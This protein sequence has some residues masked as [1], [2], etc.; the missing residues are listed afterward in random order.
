MFNN[1]GNLE[2][3]HEEV[4]RKILARDEAAAKKAGKASFWKTFNEN[5]EGVIADK[6]FRNTVLLHAVKSLQYASRQSPLTEATTS[7]QTALG[8]GGY[9]KAMLPTIITR[10]F[11]QIV[12]TKFI[13][14]R[15]LDVPTQLIQTFRL[16][17]NT[18]KN[19]SSVG[20]EF[21]DPSGYGYK[22]PAGQKQYKNGANFDAFYSSQKVTELRTPTTNTAVPVTAL[23]YGTF[24]NGVAGD[25]LVPNS[26]TVSAVLNVDP[27]VRLVVAIQS[28]ATLVAA[29]SITGTGSVSG[30]TPTWTPN[31]NDNSVIIAA[32][33]LQAPGQAATDYTG[34]KY[35]FSYSYNQERNANMSE[36]S[37]KMSTINAVA[38]SRKNFAQISAE[39]IQD[40]EAYSEGK[41]DALKELVSGMTESMA[42][43]ID[44]E[45]MLAMMNSAGKTSAYDA[46]YPSTT[47]H[48]TT[49]QKNQEL[50][51]RMNY[52]A[53][54]MSIDFLRGEGMF[55]I[56]HPHVFTLLQ[57]TQEFR[58]NSVDH[59]AQGTFDV[60]ADK[61][62]T[63]NN[64]TVAKA[65]QF[66][67][68]DRVLMGFTSKDLAKAPYAYFPFVT[69]LTP[70]SIDVRSGDIFSSV[71]GLQQRYDHQPLLDGS[72]GLG[73]L[74][75]NNL[76]DTTVFGS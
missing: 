61:F 65:P 11:P 26:I 54:D 38:K 12:A 72:Y 18:A 55:A 27:R 53:N 51:H 25:A 57:N 5:L 23:S 64:F 73:V 17:K 37:F 15:Q 19:G 31:S 66:P 24:P 33:S 44:L 2:P 62:G 52:L 6:D 75:V 58:M 59:K 14:T 16:S 39:A 74:T 60:Q 50:V 21:F 69:Y 71:V 28:G 22:S 45:I 13:A 9:N 43:E 10:V 67:F 41:L 36:I 56:T 68:S 20:D 4:V 7:G 34:Y 29:G 30:A 46:K 49:Y 70:P 32:F 3:L 35:E 40:L 76:Y 42:L 1:P 8:A 47:F 48:G 63:V